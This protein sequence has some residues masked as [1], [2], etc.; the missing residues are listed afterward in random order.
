MPPL[1]PLLRQHQQKILRRMSVK[2]SLKSLANE[3]PLVFTEEFNFHIY[4]LPICHD[5]NHRVEGG[6]EVTNPE[7]DRYDNIWT[8]TISVPTNGHSQVPRKEGKPAE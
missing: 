1:Q 8:G 2:A 7:E 4:D 6:I 5:V 3:I